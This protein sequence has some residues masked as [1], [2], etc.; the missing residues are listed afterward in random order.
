LGGISVPTEYQGGTRDFG[1]TPIVRRAGG[2][3]DG[4]PSSAAYVEFQGAG[5]FA[6]TDINPTMQADIVRYTL[7]WLDYNLRDSKVAAVPA[8]TATVS[9]LRAK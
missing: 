4:T 7:S 6:W 8:K 9:D 5:H 2:C 1:I 3:Y